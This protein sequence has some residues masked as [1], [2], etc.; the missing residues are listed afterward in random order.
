MQ[1]IMMPY[2]EAEQWLLSKVD[3]QGVNINRLT[4]GWD[5]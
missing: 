4:D 3:K 2:N 5:G 1:Q